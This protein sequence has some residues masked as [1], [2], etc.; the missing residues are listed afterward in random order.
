MALSILLGD[1]A[2]DMEEVINV[3]QGEQEG[4]GGGLKETQ[5]MPNE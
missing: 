2:N 1:A 5:E 4:W 3:S